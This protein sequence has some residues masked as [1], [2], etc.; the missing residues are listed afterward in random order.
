MHWSV[1][2]ERT[3]VVSKK[4]FRGIMPHANNRRLYILD[5]CVWCRSVELA[6]CTSAMLNN[7]MPQPQRS[8]CQ[9]LTS[10]LDDLVDQ[11]RTSNCAKFT[12]L[13]NMHLSF[14]L[15]LSGSCLSEL[16]DGR[17]SCTTA[18][19]QTDKQT[20]IINVFSKKKPPRGAS[21]SSNFTY[22]WLCNNC[23]TIMLMY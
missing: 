12:A 19:D 6:L 23:I 7:T 3:S 16:I 5:I 15:D 14:L 17:S 10:T 13:V 11:L 1:I 2:I 8:S 9:S 21:A 20:A 4:S 18:S 22:I